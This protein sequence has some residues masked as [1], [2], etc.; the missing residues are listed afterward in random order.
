MNAGN[1]KSAR[2]KQRI[3]EEQQLLMGELSYAAEEIDVA[4]GI[5]IAEK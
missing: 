4:L 5:M 2:E 3:M 1:E